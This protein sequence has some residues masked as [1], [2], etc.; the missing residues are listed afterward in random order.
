MNYRWIVFDIDGVLIDVN[1]SYDLATK[2]TVEYILKKLGKPQHIS[3]QTI[4]KLRVRGNFGDDFQLTEALLI[5]S[6]REK[7]KTVNNFPWGRGLSW[8][9]SK[10]GTVSD[11]DNLRRDIRRVFNTFYLGNYYDE[12]LF[13][14]QGLVRNE[15][16]LIE[17]EILQR[18]TRRFKIGVITGRSVMELQMAEHLLNFHFPHAVTREL[19]SKPDPGALRHIV[20]GEFGVYI[21]DSATDSLLVENY[22]IVCGKAFDFIMVGRDFK[23][24]SDAIHHILH[25]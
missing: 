3:L 2:L 13:P 8:V 5:L 4:R 14:F 1:N 19:Y 9:G 15:R 12:R 17:K 24:V 6:L 22:R 20:K 11:I 23:N 18:I 21:G 16:P 10:F 7:L 25:I